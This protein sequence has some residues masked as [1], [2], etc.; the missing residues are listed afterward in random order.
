MALEISQGHDFK[1]LQYLS[2][3]QRRACLLVNAQ[4]PCESQERHGPSPVCLVSLLFRTQ[5]LQKA[6]PLPTHSSPHHP[7]HWN[8]SAQGCGD[9]F[10]DKSSGPPAVLLG[11]LAASGPADLAPFLQPSLL[12][13]STLGFLLLRPLLLLGSSSSS[14]HCIGLGPPRAS[15]S[16]FSWS[17]T[18]PAQLW[19]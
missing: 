4:P 1:S 13:A 2:V 3:V 6:I 8:C 9:L 16:A 7:P 10:V 11:L 5:L 18:F 17:S 12:L 19:R 14:A 15:E